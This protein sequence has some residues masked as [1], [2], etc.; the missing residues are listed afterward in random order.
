[1]FGNQTRHGLE[2]T[3]DALRGIAQR[4]RAENAARRRR[5]AAPRFT[6][7]LTDFRPWQVGRVYPQDAALD[8]TAWLLAVAERNRSPAAERP[9]AEQC[10]EQYRERI[11]RYGA[12]SSAIARRQIATFP[13]RIAPDARGAPDLPVLFSEPGPHFLAPG[14]EKRMDHFASVALGCFESLY[15]DERDAPDDLIHVSCSGYLSPSP[16]QRYASRRGWEAT[17]VLH[18]YH[19]GCYGAFPPVQMALGLLASAHCGLPRKS[20]RVDVVHTEL[21]SLHADFTSVDPGSLVNMTLFADGFV[22]YSLVPSAS[23]LREGGSGLEVLAIDSRLIPDSSD[24]MTWKP[25]SDV[26]EMYLS[27][28]VP[29]QIRSAIVPFVRELSAQAG[30]DFEAHKHDLFYAVHPGGP[31]ILDHVG[32]ALGIGAEK[33]ELSRKILFEHGNMSSATIPHIWAEA[34][35]DPAVPEGARIVSVAFGPGLTATGMVLRKL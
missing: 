11:R 33:L 2:R 7:A 34:L 6:A 30:F 9:S 26:F 22:R 31:K 1:M 27:K 13:E 21:L 14:L 18:S 19:M 24:E 12:S 20:T 5:S 3:F 16:A 25:R 32:E 28:A 29:A 15:R 23:L 4:P 8:Y 17:R 10:F 35:R